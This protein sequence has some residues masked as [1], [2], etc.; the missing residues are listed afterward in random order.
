MKRHNG[1]KSNSGF[2][3]QYSGKFK[4]ISRRRLEMTSFHHFKTFVSFHSSLC[5]NCTPCQH[6]LSICF[7]VIRHY[8][9][10]IKFSK[11]IFWLAL[12]EIVALLYQS[13]AVF[14]LLLRKNEWLENFEIRGN[15]DFSY[16]LQFKN[17][18]ILL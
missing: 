3:C 15:F 17:F 9:Q 16:F 18:F 7:R 6:M 1:M 2:S 13:V 12:D 5:H 14:H 10:L 11:S 8:H 4:P